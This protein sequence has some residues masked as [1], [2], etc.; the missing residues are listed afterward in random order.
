VAE[1]IF[2]AEIAMKFGIALPGCH[3]LGSAEGA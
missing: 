1:V 2:D 3:V